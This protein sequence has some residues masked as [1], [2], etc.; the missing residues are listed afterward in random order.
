MLLSANLEPDDT[1]ADYFWV[2]G[3][4]N[5]DT[6]L[7]TLRWVKEQRPFWNASV[8]EGA[9]R[10]VLAVGHEEGWAEVWSLL[11]RWLSTNGD[12]ENRRGGWDDLHPASPTRQLAVLQLSGASDYT[13][14]GKPPH[15]GV[16]RG[17]HCRV[18]FQPGKDVMVPGFPGIMDYPDF[19]AHSGRVGLRA[20]AAVGRLRQD[21]RAEPTAGDA[22]ALL[23]GGGADEDARPR[24]VR[25]EPRRA[26]LL[27]EESVE[28]HDF[29]I[30]QTNRC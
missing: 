15:R 6:I 5:G 26:V 4:P 19:S 16:S 7:P 23:R 18:C 29:F 12:H 13:P 20:A 21:R 9:A 11:G 3:C 27:L 8:Q 30:R 2:Y 28:E 14:L 1:K 25:A 17:A 10:H 22:E 24:A